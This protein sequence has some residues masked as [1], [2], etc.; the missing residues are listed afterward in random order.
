MNVHKAKA[1]IGLLSGMGVLTAIFVNNEAVSMVVVLL[2]S[3]VCVAILYRY[4]PELS[5]VSRDNPKAKTIR[6]ITIANVL[7][8]ACLVVFCGCLEYGVIVLS[9]WQETLVLPVI[10]GALILM[11]GNAAPKLPFNRYTGLRLPWTVRDEDAW[12]V[13]HRVLGY[14]SLPCG[15]LCFAGIGDLEASVHIPL[16]A[17]GIWILVPAVLS[18]IVYCRKWHP[19]K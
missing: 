15:I 12:I 13:A 4:L 8:V 18:G 2:C 7:V 9:P 14:L 6:A 11:F 19:R 3:L 5:Q 17:L 1:V 16:L 10:F